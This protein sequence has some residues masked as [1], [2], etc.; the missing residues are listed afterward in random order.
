MSSPL[1]TKVALGTLGAGT[2]A[3]G[4]V[5]LGKDLISSNRSKAK[6]SI[7]ALIE[8]SNPEKRLIS[9]GVGSNPSWQLAWKAYR[10]DNRDNERDIWN[11]E[12][13]TQDKGSI[14]TVDAP[15]A[16]MDACESKLSQEVLDTTDS[17]YSQVVKYCTRVTLVS[18]LINENEEKSL[19]HR[20]DNFAN[21]EDWKKVWAAYKDA[22]KDLAQD[23]WNLSTWSTLKEQENVPD[24]FVTKCEQKSKAEE[25]KLDQPTYLDVLKY[26]TKSE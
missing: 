11:V 20:G 17:L 23:E 3:T 13:W 1:L 8:R 14:G 24:A 9:F 19:L 18:D 4:A 22:N 25:Y 15:K 2:V 26:C 16:F 21:N 7:E 10:E 5:Y 6:T 12:G